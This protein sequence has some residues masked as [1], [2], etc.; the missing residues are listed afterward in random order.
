MYNEYLE[1]LE[2][3][4]QQIGGYRKKK[5]MMNT[6]D[7]NKKLNAGKKIQPIILSLTIS[8]HS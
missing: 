7:L 6:W 8:K 3:N 2:Q 5:D 4:V 1:E